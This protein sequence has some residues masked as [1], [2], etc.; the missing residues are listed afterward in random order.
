M[1]PFDLTFTSYPSA[2]MVIFPDM[3]LGFWRVGEM[4]ELTLSLQIGG[5]VWT[6]CGSVESVLIFKKLGAG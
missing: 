5:I 1:S 4:M 3:E 2:M 6:D